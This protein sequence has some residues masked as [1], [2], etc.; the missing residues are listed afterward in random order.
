MALFLP[1]MGASS[2]SSR[3]GTLPQDTAIQL[4]RMNRR[5]LQACTTPLPGKARPTSTLEIFSSTAG[6]LLQRRWEEVYFSRGQENQYLLLVVAMQEENIL[7]N[8]LFLLFYD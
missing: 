1:R 2:C 7:S 3:W 6:G 5:I 4:A 8:R